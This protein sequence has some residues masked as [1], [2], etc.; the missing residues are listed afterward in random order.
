MSPRAQRGVERVEVDPPLRAGRHAAAGH[1]KDLTHALVRVMGVRPVR[2]ALVRMQLPR[3]PQRLEVRD[4][5][6]RRQ[7][8]EVRLVEA[9]H[10]GQ[11]GDRLLLHLAR[12]RPAVERVV[13]RVDQHRGDVA[14]GRDRVRRLQHLARVARVEERVVAAHPALELLPRLRPPRGVDGGR[15]AGARPSATPTP[16]TRSSAAS[17]PDR[18]TPQIMPGAA[19][20][21]CA[22]RSRSSSRGRGGRAAQATGRSARRCST[23]R[24]RRRTSTAL[25][26]GLHARRSARRGGCGAHPAVAA[27]TV[28]GRGVALLRSGARRRRPRAC[29]RVRAGYAIPLDAIAVDPRGYARDRA[30]RRRAARSPGLRRGAIGDLADGGRRSGAA[31]AGGVLAL[32]GGRRAPRGRRRRR[33][34]AARRRDRGRRRATRACRRC[35]PRWSWRCARRSRRA[36]LVRAGPSAAPPRG[37]WRAGR[38]RRP[39]RSARRGPALLKVRFGEP[40]VG[41]P[42]GSDWIRIDPA[43]VRRHIVTRRVR[44]SAP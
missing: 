19:G 20:A 9:E 35:A 15:V 1:P 5:A 43:F 14:G 36:Q 26:W 2:H 44:S 39:D 6:A 32:A 42:Y 11:L 7:V 18:F 27:A 3:H 17:M 22:P 21:R 13:V 8:P 24:R 38:S 12:R 25:V 23:G 41:L 29:E 40:A 30:A 16:A 33:R 28:L 34:G 37:S 31:V 10:G 4:R